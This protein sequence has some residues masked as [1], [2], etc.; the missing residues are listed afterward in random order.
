[1]DSFEPSMT[2]HRFKRVKDN[3]IVHVFYKKR[4]YRKYIY[5]NVPDT[6][7]EIIFK[8]VIRS[9]RRKPR[10]MTNP[11]EITLNFK[12]TSE[13]MEFFSLYNKNGNFI[14]NVNMS[15]VA[16]CYK[17]VN[18]LKKMK[19]LKKNKFKNID[20]DHDATLPL[21]KFIT[22]ERMIK[23]DAD[24]DGTMDL[25]KTIM[26]LL[27]KVSPSKERAI[28][29]KIS[30]PKKIWNVWLDD[31]NT[32]NF[33]S[34]DQFSVHDIENTLYTYGFQIME[35]SFEFS[36]MAKQRKRKTFEWRN[37]ASP[38]MGPLEKQMKMDSKR[39]E[40]S[41]SRER[42][43]FEAGEKQI[44]SRGHTPPIPEA[45]GHFFREAS[46]RE[47]TPGRTDPSQPTSRS[48]SVSSSD[49][50]SKIRYIFEGVLYK[51]ESNLFCGLPKSV[52][53]NL[54]EVLNTTTRYFNSEETENIF[55]HENMFQIMINHLKVYPIR[56]MQTP[57][58]TIEHSI[59][60]DNVIYQLLYANHELTIV[61]QNLD[62]AR[63]DFEL[64][65]I[66]DPRP[67][68]QN[69]RI[70]R[71]FENDESELP[72]S[73][74]QRTLFTY[75]GKFFEFLKSVILSFFLNRIHQ[76]RLERRGEEQILE[77]HPLFINYFPELML[78]KFTSHRHVS[79]VS[80]N[81]NLLPTDAL[82]IG[83]LTSEFCSILGKALFKPISENPNDF[84]VKKFT[85]FDI[86]TCS[87]FPKFAPH[88]ADSD[89]RKIANNLNRFFV[90]IADNL[91]S[92]ISR[93]LPESFFT[94]ILIT[95]KLVCQLKDQRIWWEDMDKYDERLSK[96]FFE[97]VLEIFSLMK[98]PVSFVV[99]SEFLKKHIQ[100]D[101]IKVNDYDTYVHARF[102]DLHD[103]NLSSDFEKVIQ[104]LN[105][106]E[107]YIDDVNMEAPFEEQERT[108]LAGN[109]FHTLM[110][111]ILIP[112][113]EP[114]F[115][116]LCFFIEEAEE[117][118]P[119][120]EV[121][122]RNPE[123]ILGK[124]FDRDT[125]ANCIVVCKTP[126]KYLEDRIHFLKQHIKDP[127]TPIDWVKRFIAA[128]TGVEALNS[129]TQIKINGQP[130]YLI[131]SSHTCNQTL[132]IYEGPHQNYT[133]APYDT[134]L[135]VKQRF[136]ASIS[137][138][139]IKQNT[140]FDLN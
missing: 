63:Q 56:N 40:E 130:N 66:F 42:T 96:T 64:H 55:N 15:D 84:T 109:M 44:Y 39:Q 38:V 117:K 25:L 88:V 21:D 136:I 50:S 37:S 70:I 65:L 114:F 10:A 82:D 112:Y 20:R 9:L 104:V 57:V 118:F 61:Q 135:D 4:E 3:T 129:S 41:V 51:N 124:E 127:T 94:S 14:E 28:A 59:T 81:D 17:K 90:K 67:H 92:N 47:Q 19:K 107:E 24:Q 79:F 35:P 80:L 83:G 91:D 45:M 76:G 123:L 69:V 85:C 87:R 16:E 43:P 93:A 140:G 58:Y 122:C 74:I 12:R 89:K 13:K 26:I 116:F 77:M 75:N 97:V 48:S 49:Q 113:I 29:I 134:H 1:M 7:F 52:V 126:T 68:Q 30:T 121:Y 8:E 60:Y 106:M 110:K 128:V 86:C 32:V 33:Q 139:I 11:I 99:L 27:K 125:V 54:E 73:E 137:D 2:T 62:I 133:Y 95:K 102:K 31:L 105:I 103:V 53:D 108:D 23:I 115:E 36:P 6:I 71:V 111:S 5:E 72:W 46:F 78:D 132:D 98:S 22:E 100:Y 138:N 120:Y 34:S 131:P 119:N 101:Q 18:E